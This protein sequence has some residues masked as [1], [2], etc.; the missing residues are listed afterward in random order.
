MKNRKSECVI[1]G[2]QIKR[3]LLIKKSFPTMLE[4][5]ETMEANKKAKR[6]HLIGVRSL[7]TVLNKTLL[8]YYYIG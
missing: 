6:S 4:A 1:D 8:L 2:R 3:P 7:P 5:N